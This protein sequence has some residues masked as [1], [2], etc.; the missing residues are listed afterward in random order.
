MQRF[1]SMLNENDNVNIKLMKKEQIKKHYHY[2]LCF[3]PIFMRVQSDILIK[4]SCYAQKWHPPNEK[5]EDTKIV[6]Q[7]PSKDRQCNGHNK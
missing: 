3:N 2:L 6:N 7:N 1:F 5:F 4:Q